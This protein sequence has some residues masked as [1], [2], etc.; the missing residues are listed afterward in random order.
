[1]TGDNAYK[2]L[3]LSGV[4]GVG[5]STIERVM[6][7]A[8]F[9]SHSLYELCDMAASLRKISLTTE[10]FDVA[11]KY[12]E[13]QVE[14]ALR[15]GTQIICPLDVEYPENL[16]RSS[17]RLA[18]L[19]VKGEVKILNRPSVAIIGTREPTA[20]GEEIAK[21]IT[22]WMVEQKW[23]VVSGL[24]LGCDSIA[25]QTAVTS[26]GQTVAVMAH[27]LNTVSPAGNKALA[28]SIID[29]GGA[30]VS[31]FGFDV[32]PS[33]SNFVVRDK[34]QSGLSNG[35]IIIQ[36]DVK[37]G[38]L[39]ASRAAIKDHRP[40]IVPY[41][42]IKDIEALEPKICANLLLADGAFIEKCELLKCD[43]NAL[44]NICIIKTSA[45]YVDMLKLLYKDLHGG[46]A[47]QA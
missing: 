41:P 1:M 7:L 37:G 14:A 30:L 2:A 9:P 43:P 34:T 3:V 44:S 23:V 19:Y 18:V 32:K 6:G 33:P 10:L 47:H 13:F 39:H 40:L 35:V 5:P 31:E 27:G 46:W 22:R 26:G 29:S 12:A 20:H 38:S 11:L 42:T 24:A 28:A 36:S 15:N 45:D 16:K 21:R 8:S 25:H 17:V 4:K